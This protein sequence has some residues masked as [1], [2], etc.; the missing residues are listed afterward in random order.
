MMWRRLGLTAMFALP[1]ILARLTGIELPPGITVIVYGAGVVAS[2]VLLSWAAE[3][4]QVDIS[5]SLAI[6]ILALIAV[7]PEYAVDL[8][9]SFTAGSN[10]EYTQFA[11]ANMTGSNRLLIGIG[12]PLVAFVGFWAM[13]RARRRG[14]LESSPAV[15]VADRVPAIVLPTRNR[16]ELGFLAVASAYAFLIP[17]TRSIAWYDALVLLALFGAYLWRVTREGRGEPELIGVAADIAL[18]PQRQRRTLVTGLFIAAAAIVVMAAKPFADGLV[19]TGAT[20]GI[21]QFLLVQWLAPLSSEAPEL[22]VA[23]IFAWRLHAADG[24]GMLLS[25]KVNQWTLLVG[26]LWVAYTLGGGAGAPLPLDDRQTEEFLLTSAQAL[27]AFAVLA[28]LRFGLWEAAAIFGLFILQF[29]FPNTEVRLVFSA[30]YMVVALALLVRKRSSLP[31]IIGSLMRWERPSS[32]L[33][34]AATGAQD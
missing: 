8:Y 24:L 6:A 3:A 29:P 15:D 9:F 7:L 22:I 11:A 18:L 20:L 26:S 4:A 12:W 32:D 25:A 21:D 1:A 30:I 17:L 31:G 19:E 16:V 2:A 13:R 10:P 5:G 23:T 28:D 33:Q 27:L 34:A 14:P